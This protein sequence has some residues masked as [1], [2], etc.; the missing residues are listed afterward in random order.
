MKDQSIKKKDWVLLSAYLDG[1]LRDRE[2][3]KLEARLEKDPALALALESLRKSKTV[4]SSLP[5]LRSPRNYAL[6]PEMVGMKRP[7]PRLYPT[8]RLAS[9]IA[10][11]MLMIVMIGDVFGFM[12]TPGGLMMATEPQME[13]AQ[14]ALSIPYPEM[15]SP[16]DEAIA[17]EVMDVQVTGEIEVE[18]EMVL[19]EAAYPEPESPILEHPEKAVEEIAEADDIAGM[20]ATDDLQTI[21]VPADEGEIGAEGELTAADEVSDSSEDLPPEMVGESEELIDIQE[22][23]RMEEPVRQPFATIRILEIVLGI[24]V[25]ITG[26]T[27]ILL[28]RRMFR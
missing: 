16:V 6:T 14:K 26:S 20:R 2:R 15:E 7:Q 10:S 11:L 8:F 28:R 13:N 17:A 19:M 9:V 18:E 23:T 24:I 5:R 1:E 21:V 27:A 25:I 4:L 3:V 22:E 12:G